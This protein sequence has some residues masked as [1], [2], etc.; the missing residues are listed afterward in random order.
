MP[1]ALSNAEQSVVSARENH[2]LRRV[3]VQLAALNVVLTLDEALHR[4]AA[5][6]AQAVARH[7]CFCAC[8]AQRTVAT[9]RQRCLLGL[10][11][12]QEAF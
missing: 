8:Q 5:D 7:E 6:G 12:V 1:L 3:H 2:F 9:G 11:P 4:A 10:F